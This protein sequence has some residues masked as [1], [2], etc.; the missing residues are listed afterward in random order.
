MWRE[1]GMY[2]RMLVAI[3]AYARSPRVVDPLA[4]IRAQREQRESRFLATLGR[5]VFANPNHP[6]HQMFRIAGCAP[7]DLERSIRAEGLE[8][9]LAALRHAGVFLTHD[10]FKGRAP[11]VRSGRHIAS[12]ASSFNNPLAAGGFVGC[13]SGSSGVPVRTRQ[14]IA[15]MRY[16]EAQQYLQWLELGVIDRVHVELRSILPSLRSFESSLAAARLER[17][18]ARW[19]AIAGPW[20]ETLPYRAVTRMNVAAANLSG[21]GMPRPSYLP[22]NDF[23]MVAAWIARERAAGRLC[24]VAGLTS[25]TVRV[26][27]AAVDGGY[28]IRGTIFSGG[29]EAVTAAKRRVVASAGAE[30]YPRYHI[31][32]IGNIGHACRQMLTGN[33]VHVYTDSVAVI[34]HVRPALLSGTDVNALLFTTLLP[35]APRILIN[36]DMEDAGAIAASQCDCAYARAGLTTVVHDLTS[37]GKL[38]GHGMTLVGTDL[39]AVIETKLPARFGG[40]VGDYQLVECDTG[41]QTE[42]ILRVSPRVGASARAVEQYFIGELRQQWGGRLAA[43]VWTHAGAV[44]V[45]L[46]EP[47]AGA[48]GKV[49]PLHLMKGSESKS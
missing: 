43:D 31:T 16:A 13:S 12:D 44:R 9:T 27:A 18:V 39:V 47:L 17:P 10:E 1:V 40:R 26:A 49:L 8:S 3:A 21:T 29:G 20:Q 30:I 48:T 38:T 5:A 45:V 41:C 4:V 36:V 22:A 32:E 35:S 25:P 37:V 7:G 14:S 15:F 6:Y 24:A 34:G 2:S 33:S 23:T 42:V 28:D 11:I 46:A 19:F